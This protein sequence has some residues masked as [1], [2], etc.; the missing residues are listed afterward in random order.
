MST[1][2]TPSRPVTAAITV[3]ALWSVA[4]KGVSLWR[5][6]EQ[7]SKPWFTALLLVNSLG[8]LDMI[9]LYKVAPRAKGQID[10]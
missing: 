2:Q 6:A 5:A 7:R 4:W 1:I 8:I 9:Y 3:L 10:S